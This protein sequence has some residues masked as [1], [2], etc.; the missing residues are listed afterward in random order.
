MKLHKDV[1]TKPNILMSDVTRKRLFIDLKWL[2]FSNRIVSKYTIFR[3]STNLP[4]LVF[5]RLFG[6]GIV[7]KITNINLMESINN[8][9]RLD[10]DLFFKMVNQVSFTQNHSYPKHSPI[11]NTQ[12]SNKDFISEKLIPCINYKPD[13]LNSKQKGGTGT[14]YP[15]PITRHALLNPSL[16]ALKREQSGKEILEFS[17]PF[18]PIEDKFHENDELEY[19]Q[20]KSGNSF[21]NVITRNSNFLNNNVLKHSGGI[22]V[23]KP[24][25]QKTDS[26]YIQSQTKPHYY[27]HYAPQRLKSLYGGTQK[28]KTLNLFHGK[29]Q[30]GKGITQSAGKASSAKIASL[31]LAMRGRKTEKKGE[32]LEEITKEAFPEQ[33]QAG[34]FLK[35]ITPKLLQKREKDILPGIRFNKH[36][37]NDLI[38]S[39]PLG[40]T[41]LTGARYKSALPDMIYP[42]QDENSLSNRPKILPVETSKLI[43]RKPAMQSNDTALENNQVLQTEKRISLK[44]NDDLEKDFLKKAPMPEINIIAD[45]VYKIIENRISVEKERRGWV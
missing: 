16:P 25:S 22:H 33:N 32:G 5:L 45:K 10:F 23:L 12:R 9:L 17:S 18:T 39:T 26:N 27:S 11:T 1:N 35:I 37:I 13:P 20:V 36:K 15:A 31:L 28:L 7:N 3:Q 38:L 40:T 14:R 19:F 30:K 29:V 8:Y 42:L 21:S 34:V 44:T 2:N 4:A 43:F 6:T 24:S 41:H